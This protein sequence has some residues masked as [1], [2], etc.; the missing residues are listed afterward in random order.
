MTPHGPGASPVDTP[1]STWPE[2]WGAESGVE[3]RLVE[4]GVNQRLAEAGLP[5]LRED[6]VEIADCREIDDDLALAGP[7]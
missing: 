3:R 6:A 1:F 2:F 4:L 7:Q 5:K